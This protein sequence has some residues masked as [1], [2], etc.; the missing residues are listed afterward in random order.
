MTKAMRFQQLREPHEVTTKVPTKVPTKAPSSGKPKRQC[1]VSWPTKLECWFLTFCIFLTLLI[2]SVIF[3][4]LSLTIVKSDPCVEDYR[5]KV[6]CVVDAQ[7]Q[8]NYYRLHNCTDV[9]ISAPYHVI[10]STNKV[11]HSQD[12][13]SAYINRDN[14]N[15]ECPDTYEHAHYHHNVTAYSTSVFYSRNHDFWTTM[16]IFAVMIT[17][18]ITF[19]S[20]FMVCCLR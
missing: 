6:S 20:A 17:F 19:L 10:L 8:P 15:C 11:L 3:L 18:S 16:C 9:V 13:V 7:L 4:V 2:L 12:P 5:C 14:D 1:L